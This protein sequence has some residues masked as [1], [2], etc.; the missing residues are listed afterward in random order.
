M[1][2]R[3]KW[4]IW[5]SL[6]GVLVVFLKTSVSSLWCQSCSYQI[7]HLILIY[8]TEPLSEKEMP[9]RKGS[10]GRGCLADTLHVTLQ[11]NW[12]IVLFVVMSV[13]LSVRPGKLHWR[14]SKER[15][16]HHIWLVNKFS[17]LVPINYKAYNSGKHSHS[18]LHSVQIDVLS[19]TVGRKGWDAKHN[20]FPGLL[21]WALTWPFYHF[22]PL[23]SIY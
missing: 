5:P 9:K 19:L 2:L 20:L 12:C 22:L 15:C 4:L 3:V 10:D 14:W 18:V 11:G 13:S 23:F 6:Q 17:F 1:K 7:V 16:R 21:H 8:L